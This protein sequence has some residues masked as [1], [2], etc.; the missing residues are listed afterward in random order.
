MLG[1]ETELFWSVYGLAPMPEGEG[2]VLYVKA[3]L[4]DADL[5]AQIAPMRQRVLAARTER[6]YPLLDDKVL[7]A[8]NGMMIEAYARGFAVLGDPAYRRTAE[9]AADFALEHL[10]RE[11]GGLWRVH[12]LGISRQEAYL[13]DYA[14]LARGLTALY[15]ATG[16]VRW[17]QAARELSAEMVA[18]FWDQ[19]VGGFFFTEA[20]NALIVRSK[21]AQDSAM[22][23]GNAVAA[24][25]LLDLAELTGQAHGSAEAAEAYRSRAAQILSAF[26]GAMWAQPTASVH[27]TAAV[28]RHLQTSLSAAASADAP[29]G[30]AGLHAGR[31]ARSAA[32]SGRDFCRGRAF[33]H[34]PGLAHQRQPALGRFPHSHLSDA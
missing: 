14:F 18:R 27:L 10:R 4:V 28:E 22:P 29:S 12:R 6:L 11:D 30:F 32:R 19:E 20:S 31:T 15:R 26:G 9:R 24:H 7:A 17:L 5:R 34:P 33:R 1:R 3:S 8:W 13:N 16:A 21:F 2:G 23:S 25:A